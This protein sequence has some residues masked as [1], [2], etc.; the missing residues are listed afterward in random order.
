[1]TLQHKNYYK[2]HLEMDGG[3]GEKAVDY[4]DSALNEAG[5]GAKATDFQVKI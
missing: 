2:I 3:D 4:F 1:M 5:P